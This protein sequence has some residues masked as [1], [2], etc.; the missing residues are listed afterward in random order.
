VE[1]IGGRIYKETVLSDD[2]AGHSFKSEKKT[3]PDHSD[4]KTN[5]YGHLTPPR[6]HAE[7]I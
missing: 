3:N 1:Y 5:G 7:R 2:S 6:G 4:L